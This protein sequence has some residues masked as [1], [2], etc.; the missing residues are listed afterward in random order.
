MSTA[1]YE[2]REFGVGSGMPLRIAARKCPRRGVPAGR[3]AGVRRGVGRGD[4]DAARPGWG[5][6]PVVVE[7]LGWDEAFLAPGRVTETSA[8]RAAFA[9]R[10]AGR[11]CSSATRLHCSVGIGDNKL[12]A[13]IA[14]DFGKP[15]GTWQLTADNWFEVMGERP[16]DALWGIGTQDRRRSSR[17]SASTP[18]PSSPRA[19]AR[20]L[21]DRARSDDGAVVP[22]AR[23]RRRHRA[24]S[25]R[26][27]GCRAR[28]AA[29][30]PSRRTSTDWAR[31][32]RG[33]CAASPRRVAG[34]HRPARAGRRRG[35]AS[36]SATARS[37][38]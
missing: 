32:R 12:R 16:T 35:S 4:G 15:R 6:V 24:R 38:R 18:S 20:L 31:G 28:T 33:A 22:P 7:V 30:R 36:R 11:R 8:T 13:K 10:H 3:R 26:R 29:R 9:E 5:G 17:R 23:P 19:D 37:S 25:T 14:T 34:R 27:P 2:A 1:S 21:A